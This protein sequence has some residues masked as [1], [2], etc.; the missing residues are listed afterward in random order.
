MSAEAREYLASL[1]P[2]RVSSTPTLAASDP[3][4][5]GLQLGLRN[6]IIAEFVQ[7]WEEHG[8]RDGWH[9][10][11]MMEK[12]MWERL[13]RARHDGELVSV[14]TLG[15][16][17]TKTRYWQEFLDAGDLTLDDIAHESTHRVPLSTP[18][19]SVADLE[20]RRGEWVSYTSTDDE[21]NKTSVAFSLRPDNL[22]ADP[23]ASCT[24]IVSDASGSQHNPITLFH[25]TLV[26]CVPDILAQIRLERQKPW[27]DFGSLVFYLTNSI[28]QARE[29]CR[30]KRTPGTAIIRY[31]IPRSAV[32]CDPQ[33]LLFTTTTKEWCDLVRASRTESTREMRRWKD[34]LVVE[35]PYC[36]NPHET[37]KGSKATGRGHQI[38]VRDEEVAVAW[39]KYATEVVYFSPKSE[40]VLVTGKTT[41]K[42]KRS[43][44]TPQ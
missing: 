2:R 26:H 43:F 29:W 41:K 40:P 17:E 38:G 27:R 4:V 16:T 36:T 18:S 31:S 11:D 15:F 42:H 9:V 21:E 12:D 39:T 37:K 32:L 10:A 35:G 14:F 7:R 30:V 6:D 13:C 3:T 24:S 33:W 8:K 1:E 5:F 28:E 34:A 19:P 20:T 22:E 44:H 23:F 25:A